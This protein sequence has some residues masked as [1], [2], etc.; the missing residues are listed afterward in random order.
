L[1]SPPF[2]HGYFTNDAELESPTNVD[3]KL[4]KIDI[5][6]AIPPTASIGIQFI[7]KV[8]KPMVGVSTRTNEMTICANVLIARSNASFQNFSENIL[9]FLG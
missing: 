8:S 5:K 9:S 4:V 6:A 7:F 2:F 1:S 3:A